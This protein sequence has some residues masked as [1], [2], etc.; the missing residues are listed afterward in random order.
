[1][2]TD[3]INIW[4]LGFQFNEERVSITDPS[5]KLRFSKNNDYCNLK[6]AEPDLYARVKK[7]LDHL[8]TF[9]PRKKETF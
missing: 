3:G 8:A 1:M 2:P 6:N 4:E 5:N 9:C 7:A